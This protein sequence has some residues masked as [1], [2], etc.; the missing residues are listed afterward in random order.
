MDPSV[1]DV[2]AVPAG[3]TAANAFA[4]TVKAAERAEQLGYS[5]FRVA[6]HHG[7]TDRLAGTTPEVFLDRLAAATDTIRIGSGAVLLDRYR[8]FKIAEGFGTLDADE[9]PRSMSGSPETVASLLGQLAD[10]VSVDEMMIRHT[11]PDHEMR[12]G[13]SNCWPRPPDVDLRATDSDYRPCGGFL[14]RPSIISSRHTSEAVATAA[15]HVPKTAA[16]T[17]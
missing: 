11:V 10:R 9:W 16:P 17:P 6:E 4:N 15:D 8:P 2:S 13:R 1:V 12:C 14:N 5:R 3:G 7:R